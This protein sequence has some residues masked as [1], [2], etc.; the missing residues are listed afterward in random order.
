MKVS[1]LVQVVDTHTAGEPTRIVTGGLFSIPGETMEEKRRWLAEH[2]D[3][4][5]RFLPRA[6]R[7]VRGDPHSAY[8]PRNSLWPRVPRLRGVPLYV[9][10]RDNR[11]GDGLSGLRVAR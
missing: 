5:R 2:A 1:R 7:Y 6:R 3:G 9:R 10:P 11:G 4:L 8:E